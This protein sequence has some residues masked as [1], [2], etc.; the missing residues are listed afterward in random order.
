MR[1]KSL[2]GIAVALL[3]LVGC[4]GGGGGTSV[5][6]TTGN[7]TSS[8]ITS[9][10]GGTIS[11]LDSAS[12]IYGLKIV[13]PANAL[14]SDTTITVQTTDQKVPLPSSTGAVDA[15]IELLP[16]GLT[17]AKP[18]SLTIPYSGNIPPTIVTYNTSDHSYSILPTSSIDTTNKTVTVVANHFTRVAKVFNTATYDTINTGFT[19]GVDT[20]KIDNSPTVFTDGVCWGFAYYSQWYF[21]NKKSTDGNLYG[22]YGANEKLVASDAYSTQVLTKVNDNIEM[23]KSNVFSNN[24]VTFHNL[25]N[26]MAV[27]NRPQVLLVEDKTNLTNIAR[28]A[29]LVYAIEKLSNGTWQLDI[30]DNRDNSKNYPLIFD[31]KN[32]QAW[33]GSTKVNN[34]NFTWFTFVGDDAAVLNPYLANIYNKYTQYS[35]SGS[36]TING[37]GLAGAT[38]TL[39]G[40]SSGSTLTD[41]NGAYSFTNVLNGTYSITA[42]KAGYNFTP[43]SLNNVAVNG[44]NVTGQN[45]S[46]MITYSM[47]GTIHTTSN[48]G[49]ALSG[50]LVSIAGLTATTSATGAFSL[51]GIPAGTYTL[52][53]TKSG[54][55]P[56]NN[57]TYVVGSNLTSLNFFLAPPISPYGSISGTIH[58]GSNTGAGLAGATVTIAGL[59][60]TTNATGTFSIANIP[61]GTYAFSVA[62]SG[63]VTYSNLAYYVG[64][65]QTGLNFYLTVVAVDPLNSWHVRSG[66]PVSGVPLRAVSYGNSSFVAVGLSTISTSPD[67]VTWTALNVPADL[68]GVAFGNNTFL[69]AG[70]AGIVST[71]PDGNIWT[72]RSNASILAPSF[73]SVGY[74]NG[75][76]V[77]G[78]GGGLFSNLYTSPDGITSTTI[79]SG[80][81]AAILGSGYGNG[82]FVAVGDMGTILTS[83]NAS[84]WVR[85]TSGASLVFRSVA[86]GNG[87]FVV[88][89]TGPGSTLTSND[90]GVTWVSR[91]VGTSNALYGVTFGN[92]VFVAVGNAGAIL[93]STDGITWKTRVSGTFTTLSGITFGNRTFVVVGQ[94]GT[95]LQSDPN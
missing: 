43:A 23:L 24:E 47:T 56:F 80:T 3:G 74:G 36:V 68:W 22:K 54:Y 86:Y 85:R 79:N 91:D 21:N 88:V 14:S 18:I 1:A 5:G 93:T 27:S 65:N 84:T 66:N 48:S 78:A 41:A 35:I 51:T 92:G 50:A 94:D 32:F 6:A 15:T 87:I 72:P 17:F 95:I 39:G 20:F 63:Y 13:V 37:A 90:G 19:L 69:T 76:F 59:S 26:A 44:S 73:C 60:A 89:G 38:V 10:Q 83:S 7:S 75:T 16:A 58:S 11:V 2:L 67:G 70:S 33:H 77:V 64:S 45:F 9:S 30:N 12:P 4:G 52:S 46:S 34:Y 28:H 82:M 42:V 57:A 53:I 31:G 61:V 8:K 40:S 62:K 71:S 49:P 55:A 81:V 25:Y 29:V